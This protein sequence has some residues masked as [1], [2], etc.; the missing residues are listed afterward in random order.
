MKIALFVAGDKNIF[1]PAVVALSSIDKSNPG[2]F[3]L[4]ICFD[5]NDLTAEMQEVLDYYNIRFIPKRD[6]EAFGSIENLP[7]MKEGKWPLEIFLNWVLPKF[8]GA[9]GYRISIKADYDILGTAPYDISEIDP[10]EKILSGLTFD[11]NFEKEGVSK[12][13]LGSWEQRG[14]YRKGVRSYINAGFVVFNNKLYSEFDFYN[15]LK[16]V[17]VEVV[18]ECP[19]V[20]LAEQVAAAIVLSSVGVKE[21]PASYNQRVL[22]G[23]FVDE[24]LLPDIK[25]IHYITSSKPW[26]PFD[27]KLV[28]YFVKNRQA[29]IFSY[30]AI[31]LAKASENPWFDKFCTEQP[32]TLEQ[33]LGLNIIVCHRYNL[34]M[35]ELEKEL[36]EAK[37]NQSGDHPNDAAKTALLELEQANKRILQLEAALGRKVLENEMLKETLDASAK[38]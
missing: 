26:R 20:K 16:D 30:R 13:L 11:V 5:G 25:N 23:S 33:I 18:N 34:R 12:E 4:Y 1:F 32:L 37:K 7:L 3:D 14:I 6:L 29:I 35:V 36:V 17:F 15:K 27:R 38:I 9:A 10:G 2:V 28:P 21:V 8:F 22:W 31:W 19:G 24:K